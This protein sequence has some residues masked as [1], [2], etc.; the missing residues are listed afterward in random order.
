MRRAREGRFLLFRRYLRF[1]VGSASS[2]ISTYVLFLAF[3]HAGGL[4]ELGEY[5]VLTVVVA[6]A[7][8]VAVM[9]PEQRIIQEGVLQGHRGEVGVYARCFTAERLFFAVLCAV[10]ILV[11][12]IAVTD[13][14]S[15]SGAVAFCFLG[16]AM[17]GATLG[18]RILDPGGHSQLVMQ[19]LAAAVTVVCAAFVWSL[20]DGLTAG[21]M[22]W[23]FGASRMVVS[24]PAV[25]RDLGVGRR[26]AGM[27]GSLL[28]LLFSESARR[29][30]AWIGLVQLGNALT[31]SLDTLLVGFSG[32]VGVANY[33]LALRPMQGLAV[34]NGAVGQ[35]AFNSNVSAGG[36]S[37]GLSSLRSLSMWLV[38]IW[39]LFGVPAYLIS[40]IT[41]PSGSSV[42]LIVFLGLGLAG[43]LGAVAAMMGPSLIVRGRGNDVFGSA[44]CQVIALLLVGSAG[45][46]LF[47]YAGVVLGVVVAR[48]AACMF[49]YWRLRVSYLSESAGERRQRAIA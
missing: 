9:V 18:V 29:G 40:R 28:S 32:R 19:V 10:A 7:V 22:L 2:A 1:G 6:A 38:P 20:G 14:W 3:A 33:Q 27:A 43:G 42:L 41:A 13:E 31:G 26:N 15:F 37:I 17:F 30:T 39:T 48:L 5:G 46:L 11:G 44:V 25:L 47:G 34:L 16:Q 35:M 23:I 4:R 36:G 21:S 24:V 49:Q 45:V 8:N 12:F